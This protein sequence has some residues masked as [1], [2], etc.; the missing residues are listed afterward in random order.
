MD[1]L[2]QFRNQC[3]PFLNHCVA[4]KRRFVALSINLKLKA[5][6]KKEFKKNNTVFQE[7]LFLAN[8]VCQKSSQ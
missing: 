3:H 7:R 4:Q 6:F 2:S 1:F 5:Y 8:T